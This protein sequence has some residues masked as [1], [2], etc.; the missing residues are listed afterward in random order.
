[1]LVTNLNELFQSIHENNL[2]NKISALSW[3][4]WGEGKLIT[5][6]VMFG[7]VD[8]ILDYYAP[9]SVEKHTERYFANRY[10]S[11]IENKEV[12]IKT[13]EE[14]KKYFYFF[15]KDILKK[16]VEIISLKRYHMTPEGKDYISYH[17]NQ[18][19]GPNSKWPWFREPNQWFKDNNPNKRYLW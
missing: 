15:M 17:T 16:D 14:A 9:V 5:D 11:N 13:F 3:D 7:T 4:D 18:E 2:D 19:M 1:M 10:C 8:Q 6:E 12:E